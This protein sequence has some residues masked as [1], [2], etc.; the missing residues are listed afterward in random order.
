MIQLKIL[1]FGSLTDVVKSAS[2]HTD[3]KNGFSVDDLKRMLST[4]YPLLD[5]HTFNVAVNQEI[6]NDTFVLNDGDE[7]ALLPP[8]AG[9]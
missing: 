1:F 7:V 9:G 5:N 8:F 6:V 2:V 4:Q 3:V